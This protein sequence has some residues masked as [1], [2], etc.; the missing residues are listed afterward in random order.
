M[1]LKIRF[2]TSTSDSFP[3][4]W[5]NEFCITVDYVPGTRETGAYYGSENYD[6]GTDD[7]FTINRIENVTDDWFIGKDIKDLMRVNQQVAIECYC[8]ERISLMN[9]RDLY[10]HEC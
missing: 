4:Y 2:D 10:D 9:K 1:E 5:P 8:I 7:S 6:E 3:E